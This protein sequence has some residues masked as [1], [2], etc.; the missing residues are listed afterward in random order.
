MSLV[1]QYKDLLE[2]V[3]ANKEVIGTSLDVQFPN[4]S[5]SVWAS[6]EMLSVHTKE[7][8]H[9]NAEIKKRHAEEEDY[10]Q[11]LLLGL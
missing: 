9:F 4:M 10:Y 3:R 1:S 2:T 11:F 6:R 7:D 5:S 8:S